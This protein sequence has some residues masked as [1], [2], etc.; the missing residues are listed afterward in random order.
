M[1][2]IDARPDF[3]ERVTWITIALPRTMSHPE[4][5]LMAS[6]LRSIFPATYL[7]ELESGGSRI[8]MFAERPAH[9]SPDRF[10]AAVHAALRE[11]A[12]DPAAALR[13]IFD[14]PAA[15]DVRR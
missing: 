8:H 7:I 4:L 13:R 12:A 9:Q 10:R 11:A 15:T 14:A 5:S 2:I 1:T 3:R 6:Y